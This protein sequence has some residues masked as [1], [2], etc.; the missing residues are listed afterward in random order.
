MPYGRARARRSGR[1]CTVRSVVF[2]QCL[3]ACFDLVLACRPVRR[4]P[5]GAGAGNCGRMCGQLTQFAAGGWR[6]WWLS[7]Q[8]CVVGVWCGVGSCAGRPRHWRGG[9]E[10]DGR[11]RALLA[12][13]HVRGFGCEGERLTHYLVLRTNLERASRLSERQEWP[14]L[15]WCAGAYCICQRDLRIAAHVS[16]WRPYNH[17]VSQQRGEAGGTRRLAYHPCYWS[18]MEAP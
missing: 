14:R 10:H 12:A 7:V 13:G 5:S 11:H 2:R 18:V 3:R 8:G 4:R 6:G 1:C 17:T 16:C 15:I 9:C